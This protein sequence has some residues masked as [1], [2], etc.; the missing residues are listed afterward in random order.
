MSTTY[1]TPTNSNGD[2]GTST[3]S[4]KRYAEVAERVRGILGDGTEAAE[5]LKAPREAAAAVVPFYD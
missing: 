3:L 2:K 4:K 1:R 5:V